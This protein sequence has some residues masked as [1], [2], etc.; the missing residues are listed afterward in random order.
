MNIDL[1]NDPISF[2]AKGAHTPTRAS[3]YI[4]ILKI[5]WYDRVTI[6]ML[7]Q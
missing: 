4:Y 5:E 7:A 6:E 3:T 2:V 1:L